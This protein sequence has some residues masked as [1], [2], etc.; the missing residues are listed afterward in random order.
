MALGQGG[1][2]LQRRKRGEFTCSSCAHNDTIC[3]KI[4]MYVT[5]LR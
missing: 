3:V 5:S 4:G 2:L 1:E